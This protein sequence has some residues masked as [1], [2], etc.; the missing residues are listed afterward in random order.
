MVDY[1]LEFTLS[2]CASG[3]SKGPNAPYD[4]DDDV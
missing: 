3:A 2:R 1:G 4:T